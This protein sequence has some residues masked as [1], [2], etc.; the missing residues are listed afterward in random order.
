M[1][2]AAAR[3]TPMAPMP[4][5]AIR[6]HAAD[7]GFIP[8]KEVSDSAIVEPPG[9]CSRTE[10]PLFMPGSVSHAGRSRLTPREPSAR[11][12]AEPALNERIRSETGHVKP[13]LAVLLLALATDLA[14][15]AKVPLPRPRPPAA[16]VA[17]AAGQQEEKKDAAAADDE[18]GDDKKE[19]KAGPPKPSACQ[20]RLEKVARIKLIPRIAGP[21]AC[22]FD[23]GVEMSAV[24]LADNREVTL[25]PPPKLRC[26][27]AESLAAWIREDVAPNTGK[28]GSA[29]AGIAN[30]DSYECRGRNRI[31]G[32]QLSEHARGN[33][34]DL[35]ALKLA[36]GAI[37]E[38]TSA[39]VL[40][41]F[42]EALRRSACARFST[43]LGPGSDGYHEEH[44]HVDLIERTT[45]YRMCQWDMR[46]SLVRTVASP[47]LADPSPHATAPALTASSV[48]TRANGA[49][50][51]SARPVSGRRPP[52]A[53]SV[54]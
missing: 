1:T 17:E 11:N 10:T 13:I 25:T 20:A 4:M 44:V 27:M 29:L 51:A 14:L 35:R 32:A 24:I 42:R 8:P 16:A 7:G 2:T 53:S 46:D 37:A 21:G 33:A 36:N 30:F 31:V 50:R 34:I 52:A 9:R 6:I 40:R 18:E 48:A 12:Q 49:P 5:P 3:T 39:N 26:T 43:V 47:P 15:A 23:D 41:E 22:G 45:G 38:L 28:L 54:R 19:A